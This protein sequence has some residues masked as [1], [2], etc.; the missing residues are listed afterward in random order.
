MVLGLEVIQISVGKICLI[1]DRSLAAQSKRKELNRQFYFGNPVGDHVFL[2][3]DPTKRVI[4]F[5]VRGKLNPQYICP[6][7]ILERI[8]DVVY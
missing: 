5:D 6:F 7:E 1:R 8:G 3:V 2:R 4:C